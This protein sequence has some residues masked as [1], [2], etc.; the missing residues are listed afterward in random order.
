MSIDGPGRQII[1]CES[2][3]NQVMARTSTHK[4]LLVGKAPRQTCCLFELSADPLELNDLSAT[5]AS[6]DEIKR[7][8]AAIA[9]WRPGPLQ[10][11]HLHMSAPQIHGPNVPPPGL[12]I[13]PSRPSARLKM[14]GLVMRYVP[15]GR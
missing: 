8:T 11:R 12:A 2:G 10:E 9:A 7:L 15:L 1:F 13:E 6:Q 5:P 4:L 14:R 3:P